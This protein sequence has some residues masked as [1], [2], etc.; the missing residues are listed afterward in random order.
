[1]LGLKYKYATEIKTK[2]FTAACSQ[3]KTTNYC[4]IQYR[5]VYKLWYILHVPYT[6]TIK[7]TLVILLMGKRTGFRSEGLAHLWGKNVNSFRYIHISRE[8]V[9]NILKILTLLLFNIHFSILFLKMN[10][11]LWIRLSLKLEA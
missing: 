4:N 8:A 11:Y 10:L 6:A 7:Q 1:M 9:S 5:R 2:M 3:D